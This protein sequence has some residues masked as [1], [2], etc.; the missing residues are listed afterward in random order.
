MACYRLLL[1]DAQKQV[2]LLAYFLGILVGRLKHAALKYD[3]FYPGSYAVYL[4][5]LY[6]IKKFLFDADHTNQSIKTVHRQ[7][8]DLFYC[9][10]PL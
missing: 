9:T 2:Y 7:N 10:C 3:L 4:F 6:T 1:G 5:A 8:N